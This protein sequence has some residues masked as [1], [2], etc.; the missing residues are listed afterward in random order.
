LL[1]KHTFLDYRIFL[2]KNNINQNFVLFVDF[3]CS[4]N[5]IFSYAVF[6]KRFLSGGVGDRG[7]G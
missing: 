5:V 1:K 4:E 7:A 3:L 2:Q 6:E